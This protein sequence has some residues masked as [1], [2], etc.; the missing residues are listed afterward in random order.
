M[1]KV[2]ISVAA[3]ALTS[4][5]VALA[6]ATQGRADNHDMVAQA[7]G[8]P[9]VARFRLTALVGHDKDVTAIAFAPDGKQIA[10]SIDDKV[11]TLWTM[12]E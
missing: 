2:L 1:K 3:L 6:L 7:E 8:A 10:A 12:A 4:G 5:V 11:A 9:A